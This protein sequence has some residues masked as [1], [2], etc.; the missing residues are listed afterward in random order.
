MPPCTAWLSA[1]TQASAA[2]RSSPAWD[3]NPSLSPENASESRQVS[4]TRARQ[5]PFGRRSRTNSAKRNR[6]LS[7]F[8]DMD[9]TKGQ[10]LCQVLGEKRGERVGRQAVGLGEEGGLGG[11]GERVRHP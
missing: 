5:R 11:G 8:D 9:V 10:A 3:A 7:G 2:Q 6:S 4:A 1:L